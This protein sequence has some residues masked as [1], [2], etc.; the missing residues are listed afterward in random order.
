MK[1]RLFFMLLVSF[2]G[3]K[4]FAQEEKKAQDIP[5]KEPVKLSEPTELPA[6][7]PVKVVENGQEIRIIDGRKVKVDSQG[8]QSLEAV[9]PEKDKKP[10]A[11]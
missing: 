2:L 3:G 9:E 10:K 4:A 11:E 6:S 8:I 5:K 7:Q 1:K